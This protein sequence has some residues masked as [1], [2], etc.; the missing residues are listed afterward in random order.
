MWELDFH[1]EVALVAYC[2]Q[3]LFVIGTLVWSQ[4]GQVA[5]TLEEVGFV[6]RCLGF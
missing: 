1:L 3:F 5:V 6:R 4:F 2:L